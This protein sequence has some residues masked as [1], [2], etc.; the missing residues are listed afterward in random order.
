MKKISKAERFVVIVGTIIII[1][2]LILGVVKAKVIDSKKEPFTVTDKTGSETSKEETATN[3]PTDDTIKG[4]SL[5]QESFVAEAGSEL[6]QDASTYLKGDAAVLEKITMSFDAVNMKKPGSYVAT[7]TY[8]GNSMEIAIKVED[9]TPPTITVDNEQ[10]IFTL[11]ANSTLEELTKFVNA[12]AV[13]LV[14]GTISELTGWPKSLPKE[15]G[16]LVYTL[17]A[18]DATGNIGKKDITV[19]YEVVKP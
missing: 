9:T 8:D 1:A 3:S 4:I 10:V 16:T 18:K 17:Q 19:K 2:L 14:D 5:K 6:N 11:E 15:E 12:K 13:D 7:A